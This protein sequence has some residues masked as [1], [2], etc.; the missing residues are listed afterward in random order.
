MTIYYSSNTKLL[1]IVKYQQIHEL[2]QQFV[3]HLATLV[4]TIEASLQVINIRFLTSFTDYNFF[5][6]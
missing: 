5:A 3:G 4:S 1:T 2:S 6:F